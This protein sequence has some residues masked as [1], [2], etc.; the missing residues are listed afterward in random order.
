MAPTADAVLAIDI[1]TTQLKV[2][3]VDAR[4]ALVWTA[5]TPQTVTSPLPGWTEQD[6]SAWWHS[7]ACMLQQ[8]PRAAVDRVRAICATGHN[9][10]LVCLGR[11]GSPA[12]P[13][14][15]WADIRA[16]TEARELKASTGRPVDPS[17]N[18][19]KAM[20]LAAHEPE[21]LQPGTVLL[22][23]FD[24][25]NYALTG[26]C[27]AVSAV[28]G[29]SAWD[30]ALLQ[31]AAIDP[32][33]VPTSTP[34]LGSVVG[35]VHGPASQATGIAEGTPVVAGLVD[36]LASWIG[37]RTLTPGELY[38]GGGTSAGA[39]LCWPTRIDDPR[40]RIFSLPHPLGSNFMP[41][42]PMS[43]GSRFIDWL[44]GD[45]CRADIATLIA[46]A[47]TVTP[48]AD[49]L[50]ALPYLSGE[51]TPIAD[52]LARAAFV[53]LDARHSRAHLARAALESVAFAL[54]DVADVLV[55][56]GGRVDRVHVGGG[57]AASETWNQIKADVLARPVAVPEVRDSSLLGAAV[58]AAW[59]G[60]L[61]SDGAAAAESMVHM[62]RVLEP[63]PL[64]V[65]DDRFAAYRG[66][67]TRLRESFSELHR[68]EGAA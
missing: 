26:T 49:G 37:T 17:F 10:T 59:G 22:Q 24:Y 47:S 2:A 58:I 50:I 1:G 14:I 33:L 35:A 3:V 53:G 11:S 51:R 39:N 25:M 27:A 8:A 41:G 18:I 7:V 5:R 66:I 40:H 46:E 13:A 15:T 42:G 29:W 43:S 64:A 31:A 48:G 54:R 45:V 28:P 16:V 67:Y 34:P 52:P 30:P 65:Y 6:A 55:E 57:G 20:W 23:S 61:Y 36:G 32:A 60:R 44:A 63:R 21:I 4:G 68:A 12:R 56:L 9:P 19:A 62:T 38:T